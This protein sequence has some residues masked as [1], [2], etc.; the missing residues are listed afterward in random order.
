[1][2]LHSVS[3]GNESTDTYEEVCGV[4]SALCVVHR[5]HLDLPLHGGEVKG[6]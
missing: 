4:R 1:M 6:V 3:C 5:V 2:I